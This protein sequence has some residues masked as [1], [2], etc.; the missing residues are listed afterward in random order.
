MFPF[1]EA[2]KNVSR[3]FFQE[4]SVPKEIFF[5]KMLIEKSSSIKTRYLEYRYR[6]EHLKLHT[7]LTHLHALE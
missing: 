3:L 6:R 5:A 4:N 2:N 7:S 1:L